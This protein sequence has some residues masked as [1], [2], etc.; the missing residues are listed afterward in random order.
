MQFGWPRF[1]QATVVHPEHT[2]IYS[3]LPLIL[4]VWI[5][6]R[7][8][9]QLDTGWLTLLQARMDIFKRHDISLDVLCTFPQEVITLAGPTLFWHVRHH[10]HHHQQQ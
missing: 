10:H 2:S 4:R 5:V 8:L 3:T 6:V 7:S 9:T 1:G